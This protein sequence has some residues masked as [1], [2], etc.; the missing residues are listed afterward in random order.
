MLQKIQ[1]SILTKPIAFVLITSIMFLSFKMDSKGEVT[2]NAGTP[3]PIETT[4]MLNSKYLTPGQTINFRVKYDV[5]VGDKTVIAAGTT[6]KGQ[7]MRA[8]KAKGLGKEGFVEIQ[9]KSVQAVDGQQ[10]FLSGGNLYQEGE[11]KQMLA[12]MLGLFVCILLLAIKG[13]NAEIPAG[14]SVDASV[15]TT[16]KINVE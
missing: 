16:M 6:A 1:N 10:V 9:I 2:L 11:D 8:K 5:K 3:I 4:Q 14:F 15:A 12:I 13:E 7:I